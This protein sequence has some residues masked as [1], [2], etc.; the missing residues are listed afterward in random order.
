MR[1]YVATIS[2]IVV[3]AIVVIASYAAT[4]AIATVPVFSGQEG[5]APTRDIA[6]TGGQL[7]PLGAALGWLALAGA[8]GLLATRTWGRRIVG[9]VVV[10]AGGGA[11]ASALAFALTG[12]ALIDSA[13]AAQGLA[14]VESV[15]R[16]P[17]WILAMVG[18][19]AVLV[20]GALAVLRGPAWPGL[21]RR[22]ERRPQETTG[23]VGG[24]AAWDALDR[25]EDPTDPR[26]PAG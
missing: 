18:G 26:P 21:S 23:P 7:V 9:T 25:G 5:T 17:W 15:A 16:Y 20:G 3:G 19:L 6:L 8:A 1:E 4:W 13:V 14:G 12:A 10:L 24:V 11:G 22:Y 2:S